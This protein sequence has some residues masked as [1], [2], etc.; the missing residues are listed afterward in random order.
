MKK[1]KVSFKQSTNERAPFLPRELYMLGVFPGS[2]FSACL[3][4]SSNHELYLLLRSNGS[5]RVHTTTDT[6]QLTK[7]H[8]LEHKYTKRAVFE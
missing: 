6:K 2:L 4:F 7:L 5:T 8:E 3:C 1:K